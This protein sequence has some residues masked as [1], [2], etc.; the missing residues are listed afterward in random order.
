MN[1][2]SL[3]P[4]R[5]DMNRLKEIVRV[6]AKYQFGNVL[7]AIGLRN[8]LF[9]TLKLH[10]RDPEEELDSTVPERVRMVMEELGTTFIKLGQV[11]STR[12]DLVGRDIAEELSKLLDDAP[13]FDFN[14]V[15]A[16]IE[17]ELKKPI[18]EIF[19][20]FKKEPVA[21]ASIGQ[22]HEAIIKN[23][24]KVA[25]KVQRPGIVEQIEKDIVIMRYLADLVDK[26]ISS[27]KYYN[28]PAIVDEFERTI[29]KELDYILEANNAE[30]FR[31]FFE[32]DETIYSPAIYR[33]YCTLRVLTME[34][35]EGV[36][37]N[38]ILDSE[39]KINARKIVER[40]TESYFKQIFVN[41]FFHADPHP[42]NIMVQKNEVLCFIDFGMMGHLDQDFR[43]KLAELFIFMINYDVKN[44]IN[45][46][47]YMNILSDGTDR[48][49]LK[50]DIMDLM[51][52]YYGADMN[53]IGQLMTEFTMP[54]ILVKHKIKLPRDFIL[55]ARVI[56]M[57]EDLGHRIDPHFNAMEIGQK[58]VKKI[59]KERFNPL[60]KMDSASAT[61]AL[62]N[63]EHIYRDL[64]Q[65]IT[66]TLMRL[67]KGN[68]KMELEHKDLNK[69]SETLERMTNRISMALIIAA[70]IVGSSLVIL[71]SETLILQEFPY[72]GLI[73]FFIS[74][75]LGLAL[76]IS[77]IR[78]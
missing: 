47:N 69:F 62:V 38:E 27:L 61:S 25:V 32:D 13:P 60:R 75:V 36:Q 18:E 64:P 34:Y 24:D 63:I 51:D 70:L 42:A 21:S 58:M 1:F 72:M 43:D 10:L 40:G 30:R 41:G 46:L 78:M 14:E 19:T 50:Y 77:I 35:V 17:Q 15:K 56:S 55:L 8:K 31:T 49:A 68:F 48:E 23:G 29:K 20:E 57:V 9:Y 7:E 59:I 71:P 16:V 12:P 28:L 44:M 3:E 4:R 22:V 74:F 53:Q 52:R 33:K 54:N 65:S 2:S 11:L 45:Q 26:G 73:G 76:I 67:E 39:I 6:L 66:G 5:P 37:I